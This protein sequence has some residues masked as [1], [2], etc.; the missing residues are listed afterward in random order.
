MFIHATDI[1]QKVARVDYIPKKHKCQVI[2]VKPN[3]HHPGHT[4]KQRQLRRQHHR[5][6]IRSLRLCHTMGSLRRISGRFYPGSTNTWQY[7]GIPEAY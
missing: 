1:L 6:S 4:Q 3:R 7:Q 2:M 5:R